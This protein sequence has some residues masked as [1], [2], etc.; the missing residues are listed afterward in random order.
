MCVPSL[1]T[2]INRG[3]RPHSNNC[4]IGGRCPAFSTSGSLKVCAGILA[5]GLVSKVC[6]RSEI[7]TS[8]SLNMILASIFDTDILAA[9][10]DLILGGGKLL[11]RECFRWPKLLRP[12][13]RKLV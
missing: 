2:G 7:S 1:L 10:D 12:V 13:G 9:C 5:S 8:G 6:L 11:R 3:A 4:L